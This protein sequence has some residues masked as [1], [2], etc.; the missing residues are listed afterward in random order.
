MSAGGIDEAMECEAIVPRDMEILCEDVMI[1]E[2]KSSDIFNNIWHETVK[3][4][5]EK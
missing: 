1:R 5:H 3:G 4:M 2:R